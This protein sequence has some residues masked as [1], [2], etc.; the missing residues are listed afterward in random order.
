MDALGGWW[1]AQDGKA[2][3]LERSPE[4]WLVTVAPTRGDIPYSTAELLSGAPRRIERLPAEEGVDERGHRTVAIEAGVP[5]L[6]PTY[7][8]TLEGD[9]LVP[10]VGMGVYDDYDDDLG[11]PWA[12]P[13]LPLRRA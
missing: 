1:V 5:G 3:R 6:G 8:L 13:L 7:R 9:E 12:F 11:A 2:V 4:G 10:S